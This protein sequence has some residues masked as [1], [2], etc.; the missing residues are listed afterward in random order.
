MPT[1]P[2]DF[3]SGG[4]EGAGALLLLVAHG[5]EAGDAEGHGGVGAEEVGEAALLERRDAAERVGDAEVRTAAPDRG[6]GTAGVLDL[7]EGPGE[8]ERVARELGTH[9]V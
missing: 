8:G 7:V 4:D 5:A 6:G 3:S 2:S 9:R 1:R